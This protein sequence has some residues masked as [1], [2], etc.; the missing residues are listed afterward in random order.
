[1][2]R[3]RRVR[4]QGTQVQGKRQAGGERPRREGLETRVPRFRGSGRL[5]VR[6][7]V[8]IAFDKF[9]L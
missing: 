8:E 4:N 7:L 2:G 6:G 9:F 5:A 1:M 3:L